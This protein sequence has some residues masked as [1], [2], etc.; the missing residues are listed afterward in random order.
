M[1][2]CGRAF[3]VFKHI[4]QIRFDNSDFQNTFIT[5]IVIEPPQKSRIYNKTMI[6][7]QNKVLHD[8]QIGL[9]LLESVCHIFPYMS[10]ISKQKNNILLDKGQAAL[11]AAVC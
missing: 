8:K 7:K 6:A 5:P 10:H 1:N 3:E 11:C 9:E 2:L 4:N